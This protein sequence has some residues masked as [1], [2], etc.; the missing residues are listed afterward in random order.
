MANRQELSL[1]DI[2]FMMTDDPDSPKNYAALFQVDKETGQTSVDVIDNVLINSETPRLIQF[3]GRTM[4]RTV[5]GLYNKTMKWGDMTVT[6]QNKDDTT[7][8]F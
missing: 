2:D 4:G 8:L 6:A 5:V 7:E 1:Y 3:Q